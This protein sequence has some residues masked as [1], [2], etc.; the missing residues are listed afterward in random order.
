[1]TVKPTARD[2]EGKRG[3]RTRA[4]RGGEE[5]RLGREST[6]SSLSCQSSCSVSRAGQEDRTGPVRTQAHVRGPLIVGMPGFRVFCT[7]NRA[8]QQ[9]CQL[10]LPVH[11]YV[12]VATRTPDRQ[13]ATQSDTSSSTPACIQ[14]IPNVS[15]TNRWTTIVPLAIVILASALKELEEDVVSFVDRVVVSH[16]CRS[17]HL[18]TPVRPLRI[19]TTRLG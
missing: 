1:M 5:T 3:R 19:E 10:V 2:E 15:P 18:L 6:T 16:S 11:R 8:I 4:R 7:E 13:R 17:S 9:V 12:L 14:Q